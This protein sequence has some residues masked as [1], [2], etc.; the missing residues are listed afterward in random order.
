MGFDLKRAVGL[1]DLGK[2][3][4]KAVLKFIREYTV[5]FALTESEEEQLFYNIA[6]NFRITGFE[7]IERKREVE[8]INKKL[9]KKWIEMTGGKHDNNRSC[10]YEICTKMQT[11][12]SLSRNVQKLETIKPGKISRIRKRNKRKI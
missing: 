11:R 5:I 1:M 9:E 10:D 7:D 8:K 3:E 2:Y 6:H 12:T 4:S